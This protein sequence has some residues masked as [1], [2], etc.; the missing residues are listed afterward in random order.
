MDWDG[1]QMTGM[2][3][4]YRLV[5]FN[6]Q[7]LSSQLPASISLEMSAETLTSGLLFAHGSALHKDGSEMQRMWEAY[8]DSTDVLGILEHLHS[9]GGMRLSPTF[10]ARLRDGDTVCVH[11]FYQSRVM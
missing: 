2:C 1:N 3:D 4:D 6:A 7:D 10:L 9:D 8:A 5:I 11:C